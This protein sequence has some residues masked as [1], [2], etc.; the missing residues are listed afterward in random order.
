MGTDRE[1]LEAAA[2]A[3][4]M[5]IGPDIGELVWWAD[6]DTF[7]IRCANGTS[8]WWNPLRNSG[9]AQELAVKLLLEIHIEQDYIRIWTQAGECVDVSIGAGED[10]YAAARRAIVIAAASGEVERG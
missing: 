6:S 7:Q 8:K 1:L 3:A 10:R 9:Q 4:G 5:T 2:R